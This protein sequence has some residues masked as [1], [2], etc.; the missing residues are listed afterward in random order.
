MRQI[1]RE[2]YR[3]V[4]FDKLTMH[5]ITKC[6]YRNE[7]RTTYYGDQNRSKLGSWDLGGRQYKDKGREEGK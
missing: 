1:A 7:S 6:I 2:L 4:T 5:L 3:V